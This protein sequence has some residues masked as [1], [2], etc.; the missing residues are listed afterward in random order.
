MVRRLDEARVGRTKSVYVSQEYVPSYGW[1]DITVYDDVSPESLRLAKQD[2]KDY[3]DNGYNARYITRKLNNP[4]YVEP[5]YELSEEAVID[6]LENECPYDYEIKDGFLGKWVNIGSDV[7][8]S[9][10]NG[11]DSVF[12]NNIRVTDNYERRT[13]RVNTLDELKKKVD[14][15][16]KKREKIKADLIAA[17][18]GNFVESKSRTRKRSIKESISH[19]YKKWTELFNDFIK[20]TQVVER[21]YSLAEDYIAQDLDEE[22]DEYGLTEFDEFDIDPRYLDNWCTWYEDFDIDAKDPEYIKAGKKFIKDHEAEFEWT[23]LF[24]NHSDDVDLSYL[25]KK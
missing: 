23:D 3:K 22:S 2:V 5:T 4:D 9:L 10:P 21:L 6:W 11:P 24:C 14:K 8:I 15:I 16:L 17:G 1:E 25:K 18:Y 12:D 19:N 7:S 20:E 13:Y